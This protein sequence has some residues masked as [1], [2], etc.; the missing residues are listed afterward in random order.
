MS[1]LHV[2]LFPV[3]LLLVSCN[4]I[5]QVNSSPIEEDK[6][7]AIMTEVYYMDA[8]YS[9]LNSYIKDSVVF[10]EL[11]NVLDKQGIS[12]EQFNQARAYYRINEK[13]AI[14]LEEGIKKAISS[15]ETN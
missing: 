9:E 10:V 3:M 1:Y 7:I 8:H 15:K 12:L 4:E 14:Q 6:M 11:K 13:A 2:F 5:K